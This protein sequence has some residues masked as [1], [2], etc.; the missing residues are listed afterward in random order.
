[1]L[2]RHV[3]E[4]VSELRKEMAR[5]A[6]ESLSS[7][8][9][10]G[11]MGLAPDDTNGLPPDGVADVLR[12]AYRRRALVLHPD[13]NPEGPEPFLKMQAAYATLLALAHGEAEEGGGPRPHRVTLLLR[14]LCLLHRRAPDTLGDFTF[15]GYDAVL[16]LLTTAL[17]AHGMAHEHVLLALELV[18]LTLLACPDNAPF[19]GDRGAV[20]VFM[21][22]LASSLDALPADAAPSA[23]AA[24]VATLTL[25]AL[26]IVLRSADALATVAGAD[27]PQ[28]EAF[29]RGVLAA[30]QLGR[31]TNVVGAAVDTVASL[32]ASDKLHM[33][34]VQHGVL[35][36]IMLRMLQCAPPH[37]C[38]RT[39]AHPAGECGPCCRACCLIPHG[40]PPPRA[41]PGR[42]L[43]LSP[44]STRQRPCTPTS[45]SMRCAAR[46]RH[47][48]S[49][50]SRRRPSRSSALRC[51]TTRSP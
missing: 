23:D 18:W 38:P 37:A 12:K 31:A 49:A 30:T 32:L 3:Q 42:S 2:A 35:G 8:E 25:R 28:R 14:A 48:S 4:M 34:L 39:T 45:T 27:K 26:A 51:P 11:L 24:V 9:A 22:L 6:S 16:A 47:P 41:A 5:E 10:L 40:P 1:V 29:L 19:L 20:P 36:R 44:G 7:A 21:S 50:R 17:A 15:P 43:F 46:R 13:K 33:Q